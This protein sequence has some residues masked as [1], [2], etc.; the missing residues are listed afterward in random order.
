MIFQNGSDG[1]LRTAIDY[2]G[3]NSIVV[4]HTLCLI[5]HMK[6][7]LLGAT[8]RTG[9]LV[10][11]K[12]LESRY[13]VN[14]LSRNSERI[15]PQEGLT[16]FEGNPNNKTDLE[17][18]LTECDF[19]INVLNISRKSDFPWATIRTPENYLPDVMNTLIPIAEDNHLKR[20]VVC[21]AWGVAETKN[22]IPKWFRWL[23]ENSNR[24]PRRIA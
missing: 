5:R 4:I 14:C 8:G 3:N 16:I 2:K 18:A 17:N 19:V 1:S 9:K 6:I 23:I 22:D 20:I 21:S 11:E 13:E 15:E 7:L 10:L 24:T 12:A